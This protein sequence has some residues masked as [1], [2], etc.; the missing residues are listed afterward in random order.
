MT[1]QRYREK[2]DFKATPEPS[3]GGARKKSKQLSFVIQKH[4]ASHLHYDFRLELDGV[5]LSWAVPKG[6]SLDP[7]DKRLAMHVEDHPLEYGDFEGIIPAKQYG[8]GTVLLWDRGTWTPTGDAAAAYQKGR[9]KFELAGEKLRGGWNLVRT[10]GGKYAG[11]GKEAWLLIKENDDFARRGVDARIVDA[12]PE[13]VASGRTIEEIAKDTAHVWQ[14]NRSVAENVKGG[15]LATAEKGRKRAGSKAVKAPGASEGAEQS[16]RIVPAKVKGSVKATLPKTLSPELAT[17]VDTIPKG[18][19]WLHEIKYDGYRMVCRVDGNDVRILSRNG[20]DWTAELPSI[21][22]AVKRL[23][24]KSAWVDGEVAVMSPD[25][26]TSF[27]QLQNALSDSSGADLMYFVFDLPYVD[28]YDLR[29]APLSARKD[30][31][32]GVVPA[33]DSVLRYGVEVLGNGEQFIEQACKLGF[34]GAVSKKIASTYKDGARNREWIKVKCGKRQEMVI[35]GFTDP[36]G[37]RAGFGALL[38]GVYESDATLRYSGRVGTGFDD[39]LLS[40][41]RRALDKLER[42]KPAFSNPPRGYEAKG[43]HWVEPRLVGE[44]SF[45]EWTDEG[46]LRHPSFQGLRKDKKATDVVRERAVAP[47]PQVGEKPAT[48]TTTGATTRVATPAAMKTSRPPASAVVTSSKTSTKDLVVV[49]GVTISHPDKILFPEAKLTKRDLASY[50]E[51][52]APWLVPQLA[53]RPLSLVRCPDGW[54]AQCFYQKHADKSVNAEVT[55]VEVPEGKGTATYMAADSAMAVV[56][57][58]QWGVTEFHPWGSRVPKL[59]RP[60]RL[61]FDFDPDDSVAWSDIV[62]AAQLMRTLLGEL[63]LTPFLKT[64]G[65]KGLHVVVPIRPTLQWPEAKAFT[66]SVADLLVRTFP[67]RFI[68]TLSKA[69]RSGKIFIDYLRN[70]EGATAIAAYSVR[71][72]S[73]APVA[74]PIDWAEMSTDIRF[75][76]FNV[77]NVP[78]RLARMKKDP[79]AEVFDVRQAVTKSLLARVS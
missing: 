68:A 11:G 75:D 54:K 20:K 40:E 32:R 8:G 59:D 31:L 2:R 55:R 66:K 47:P 38:L 12:Q 35:G 1:L 33:G 10:H 6:P 46:T 29:N 74:T 79:W 43:V 25:G 26:R 24:V 73:G 14:S 30:V 41:L 63:Q 3:G 65:G 23:K 45:T 15:A 67:D 19:D 37:S 4:A 44:V 21:A 58:S 48:K 51:K 56:A 50:Y 22:E 69:K 52:I 28:G 39:R 53:G 61:I 64:T 72:R 49:A 62:S 36:Q 17:L 76:H 16:A 9:L 5:L 70:A 13:S 71:A 18:D 42:D 34:E 77:T 60:D 27:Q 7:A 78:A 57:L